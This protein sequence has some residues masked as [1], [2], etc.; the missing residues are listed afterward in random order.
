MQHPTHSG[1][2][3]LHTAAHIANGVYTVEN[4]HTG[5]HCTFKIKSKPLDADTYPGSRQV[6]GLIGPNNEWDSEDWLYI[7]HI[8]EN[9]KFV[10]FRKVK[11]NKWNLKGT[12]FIDLLNLRAINNRLPGGVAIYEAGRCLCCNRELTR[13]SSILANY[14]EKCARKMGYDYPNRKKKE[15]EA[16]A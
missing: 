1:P 9:H 4:L 7:G 11:D 2:Q 13:P 12:F 10:F 8:S 14:G 15:K 5:T 6:F 3:P 16:I